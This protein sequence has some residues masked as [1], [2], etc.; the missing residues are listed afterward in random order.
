MINNAKETSMTRKQ[1]QGL[2]HYQE[3][4]LIKKKTEECGNDLT[5][6]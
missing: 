5:K 4:D 2:S 6:I 1:L 3:K